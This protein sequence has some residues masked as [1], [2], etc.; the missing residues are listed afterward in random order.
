ML[1]RGLLRAEKVEYPSRVSCCIWRV[2]EGASEDIGECW[3]FSFDELDD[4]IELLTE[5]RDAPAE[6]EVSLAWDA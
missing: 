6:I 1:R 5:L 4:I 2:W 3:D